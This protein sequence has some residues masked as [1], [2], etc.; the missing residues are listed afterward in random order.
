MIDGRRRQ[1]PIAAGVELGV[2]HFGFVQL[3]VENLHRLKKKKGAFVVDF[4]NRSFLRYSNQGI[5]G[6]DL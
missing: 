1:Q 4:R 2:G 3:V 5:K 6:V